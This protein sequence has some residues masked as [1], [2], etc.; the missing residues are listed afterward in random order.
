[1]AKILLDYVFPISVIEPTPEA[2]T[3]FLKQA[4]L[5]VKPKTGQE[6][7]IG[8]VYE[9]TTLLQVAA[10]T[11]NTNATQLFAAGMSKVFI[12]L[13]SE[14]DITTAVLAIAGEAWTVL[15]SDD[16]T[17]ADM[18]TSN[19]LLVKANL[20]F[21]AVEGGSDGNDI[22][23]A[24]ITGATAGAEVVT[25]VGSAISVSMGGGTSTATQLKTA[26]DASAAA[27]ALITTAIASGQGAV[28]QAAFAISN[29]AGGDGLNVGTFDGV[30]G[31]SSDDA[32]VC[33]AFGAQTQRCGFFRDDTNGADN[34]CFAFGT[35]L[36]N[37]SNWANQQY[38]SMPFN[39]GVD[40]LGAATSLFDDKVSFVLNDTEFGNRLALFVAGGKAIIAP[41]I[42][43]NLRLDLQSRT[44]SWIAANQPQYTLTEAALLEARLQED[45]IEQR[46]IQTKWITAGV[47]EIK[48]LDSDFTAS[49]FIDISEPTALWRI[50]GEMRSTL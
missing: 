46:Y 21:T 45:I 15:I 5:V 10:R 26:L 3:A 40:T 20:T 1:M 38:I 44:L 2:S 48:L 11:D 42:K 31:F 7:N 30:V 41:Y 28:A 37:Q 16:F 4:C 6:A 39:D 17:D 25:V 14:L 49:G 12:L 27:A 32:A 47:I 13:A 35:L 24:F 8:E 22:T 50:F 33:Q 29:L 23:I 19:A 18:L 43:K 9:C 36:S 34:M